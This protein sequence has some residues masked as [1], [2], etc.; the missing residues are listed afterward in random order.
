ML[1]LS[2]ISNFPDVTIGDKFYIPYKPQ[3]SVIG[4]NFM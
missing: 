3:V 4:F 2:L 1:Q